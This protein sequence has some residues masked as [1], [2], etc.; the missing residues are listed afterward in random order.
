MKLTRMALTSAAIA[1]A[2]L[3]VLTGTPGTAH[4]ATKNCVFNVDTKSTRCFG[5][6]RESLSSA[7]GGR[8]TSVPGEA[9]YAQSRQSYTNFVQQAAA[10]AAVA[11]SLVV[12]PTGGDVIS[13]VVFDGPNYTGSSITYTSRSLCD[14]TTTQAFPTGFEGP[15]QGFAIDSL[16]PW[17]R[18]WLWLGNDHAAEGPYRQDTPY[19]GNASNRYYFVSPNSW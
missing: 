15:H 19:L 12:F 4:A 3:A 17:G 18:C 9:G 6:L 8:V 10:N 7:S 2:T 11:G 14:G 13:A 1:T 16:Q 5:S